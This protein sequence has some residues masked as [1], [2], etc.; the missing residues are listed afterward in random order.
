MKLP[1]PTCFC[2]FACYEYNKFE[3]SVWNVGVELRIIS[4]AHEVR[5]VINIGVVW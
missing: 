1:V 4:I 3:C 2:F 5:N